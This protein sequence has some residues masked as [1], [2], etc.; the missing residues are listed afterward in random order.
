MV[1]LSLLAPL[2]SAGVAVPSA[3]ARA[4][5]R[6]PTRRKADGKAPGKARRRRAPAAARVANDAPALTLSY[7]GVVRDRVGGG[8]TAV[9]SD[10]TLDGVFAVT[11]GAGSG[12]V[13]QMELRRTDGG[14]T[15][16]T[17][18]ST[19]W[20]ALGAASSMDGFLYNNSGAG[21]NFLISGG[22]TFYLFAS[23]LSPTLFSN[24][25][26]FQLRVWF[27]DGSIATLTTTINPP[28]PPALGLSFRGKVR[29]RVGKS[30]VAVAADGETDGVFGVTLGS[31]S[32]ART[33]LQLQLQRTDGSGVWDTTSTTNSWT[34]GAASSLDGSLNNNTSMATVNLPVGD[35]G[36]FYVFGADLSP[37]L[38]VVGAQFKLTAWFADG[39]I[40][41]VTTT[42]SAPPPPTL[43]L[44]YRGKVRDRVGKG[45]TALSADGYTDGVFAVT[46][47]PGSGSRTILQMELRRTSGGDGVWDTSSNTN[48]W[49]LGAAG[50]LDGPLYN[51]ASA[52]VNFSVGDGDTFYVFGGDLDPSLFV[53]GTT[54]QITVWF[55]DLSTATATT[56]MAP[57]NTAPPTITGLANEGQTLTAN[58]GSWAPEPISKTL[59]WQR[60]DPDGANCSD[61]A[62][63]NATTH[64][65]GNGDLGETLR[66]KVLASNSDGSVTV[67]STATATI[68]DQAALQALA[69]NFRPALLFD[70]TEH[71]RPLA[72]ES[73]L[74]EKLA[75]GITP[76]HKLCYLNPYFLPAELECIGPVDSLDDGPHGLLQ[77][78]PDP[79]FDPPRLAIW[80]A[81]EGE[82]E[83]YY[84]PACPRTNPSF[85]PIYDLRDCGDGSAIYYDFG[86]SA[87][88]VRYLD[89]W[90]FYRY[91]PV[92]ADRHEG[93]WEGVTVVLNSHSGSGSAIA[94]VI[95]WDHGIGFY[96]ANFGTIL[97]W[98]P[99][100][101]SD[102][103]SCSSSPVA[104]VSHVGDYVASGSHA[105]YEY[106]CTSDQCENRAYAILG[107]DEFENS[108]NGQ[109]GWPEGRFV[110][111]TPISFINGTQPPA[112]VTWQG[113]W[114][115]STG[116]GIA[117]ESP[118]SPGEQAPYQCTQTGWN[119]NTSV[120]GDPMPRFLSGNGRAAGKGTFPLG[121]C[122]TWYDGDLAAFACSPS[123]L[124]RAERVGRFDGHSN[125]TIR[126]RGRRGG[127]GPAFA[128]VIGGPVRIGARVELLGKPAADEIVIVNVGPPRT[129]YAIV[130]KHIK[131]P[132]K[133]SLQV[134][135]KAGKPAAIFYGIRAQTHVVALYPHKAK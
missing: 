127:S 65:L 73:L 66:I 62:G 110:G 49:A 112:W 75:D 103:T 54:F 57:V 22:D 29:D 133:A 86:Q 52:A 83:N 31:G 36:T 70:S 34:L 85:D 6:S 35:G 131:M 91:N 45:N 82:S 25:K 76:A 21:V 78:L 93:D 119:C 135:R 10:G 132:R 38:F 116:N 123:K 37:S 97:Q 68:I 134:I 56:T 53:G 50:S 5:L 43:S 13:V 42:L 105:S 7:Q 8:N 92:T 124:A 106:R 48:W 24:G 125:F 121:R 30:N 98:C 126:I 90:L 3:A 79:N 63:E 88:Y 41:T 28:P 115:A 72:V 33:V 95:F 100:D 108:H 96:R 18:S 107:F 101:S 69:E 71:Y 4:S 60:C 89:Y 51:N 20:W 39:S 111:A 1:I 109:S 122:G 2:M 87:N 99:L 11:V 32:G 104:A 113:R 27:A 12:N 19:G 55:A 40:A 114:G 26:Q 118:K 77:S 16:D 15:W 74:Q 59:Q 44:S 117:G 84:S 120:Q 102:Y 17:L 58:P 23:D 128:Q 47:Q 61:L 64:T 14:G 130:L 81:G 9:G 67:F 129:E 94:G 46:V 80:N